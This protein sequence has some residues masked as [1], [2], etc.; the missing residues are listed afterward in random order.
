[1]I[2]FKGCLL[3]NLEGMVIFGEWENVKGL[4]MGL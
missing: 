1:M 4:T 3:I 2:F